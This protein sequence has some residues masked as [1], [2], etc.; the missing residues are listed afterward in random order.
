MLSGGSR[1]SGFGAG[2]Q[3]VTVMEEPGRQNAL[4]ELLEEFSRAQ[5]RAKDAGG[6]VRGSVPGEQIGG[7][8]GDAGETGRV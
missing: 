7:C 5:F 4:G 6:K 2:P 8:H 1:C 3:P